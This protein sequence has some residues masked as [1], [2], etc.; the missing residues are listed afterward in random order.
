MIVIA[1]NPIDV[2]P[3]LAC[4]RLTDSHSLVPEQQFH[5]DFPDFW[6]EW[7]T[8]AIH[9]VKYNH[10]KTLGVLAAE[11]PTYWMRYEDLKMDP[12][13]VLEGLFCFLLDV[14]SIAGTVVEKCI[15]EVTQAGFQSKTA[16]KL[17][18][19]SGSLSR[20]NHMYTAE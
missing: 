6:N 8:S 19:T 3:S 2:M 12:K 17:K 5:T 4:M 16:Y 9:R 11:I 18:S 13:P 10:E 14:P 20:S 7:V 1:R 15:A